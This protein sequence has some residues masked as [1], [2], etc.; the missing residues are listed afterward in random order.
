[1]NSIILILGYITAPYVMEVTVLDTFNNV[2]ACE[3]Q[4]ANFQYEIRNGPYKD[5]AAAIEAVI[6]CQVKGG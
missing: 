4:A 1:M 3:A 5:T 2:Q 6:L